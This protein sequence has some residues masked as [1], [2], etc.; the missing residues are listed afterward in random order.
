MLIVSKYVN[1]KW[2]ED[3]ECISQGQ[4]DALWQRICDE[5]GGTHV[6]IVRDY[7]IMSGHRFFIH[8]SR[9]VYW[10]RNAHAEAENQ[11]KH[12]GDDRRGNVPNDRSSLVETRA[13]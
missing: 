5:N 3:V 10:Q 12:Q 1:R 7:A 11:A 9:D 13:S 4:E 8:P 2:V 6:E